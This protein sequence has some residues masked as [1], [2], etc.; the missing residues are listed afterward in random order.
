[1]DR[2]T[3]DTPSSMTETLMNL[4]Y[5]QDGWVHIRG[6]ETS[7]LQ[8]IENQCRRHG[9][10]LSEM[11]EH[12]LCE[13]ICDCAFSNHEC[14]VF[15]LHSVATQAAELRAKLKQ[16]EDAEEQGLLVRLR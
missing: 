14:P 2:L 1:M 3:T 4:A 13:T 16:Y 8:Y 11:S 5:A 10:D 9:C 12:E 6:M 7:F 15:L